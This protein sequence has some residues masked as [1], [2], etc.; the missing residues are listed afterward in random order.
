M[1]RRIQYIEEKRV[2]G[3]RIYQPL[4]YPEIQTSIADIYITTA[5][6]DRLDLLADQ[7]YNNTDYWWI[8]ANA[9]PNVLRR[10]SYRIKEGIELRIPADFEKVISDFR[11]LNE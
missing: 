8:I 3:K 5:V 4:K 2:D 10:D 11:K 9:N 7:F 6:G 1:P